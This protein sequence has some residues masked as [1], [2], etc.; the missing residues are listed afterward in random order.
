MSKIIYLDVPDVACAR[1]AVRIGRGVAINASSKHYVTASAG[2]YNLTC[3]LIADR[4]QQL[5]AENTALLRYGTACGT[6]KIVNYT[7]KKREMH[8]EFCI[9]CFE[10][11]IAQD[12]CV[13]VPCGHLFACKDCMRSVLATQDGCPICRKTIKRVGTHQ[14]VEKVFRS[15]VADV[16]NDDYCVAVRFSVGRGKR[17]K[18]YVDKIAWIENEKDLRKALVAAGCSTLSELAERAPSVFWSVF[19]F[20]REQNKDNECDME[21]EMQKMLTSNTIQH[22]EKGNEQEKNAKGKRKSKRKRTATVDE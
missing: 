5:K 18:Q 8:A 15:G 22:D 20:L 12:E 19:I 14:D 7:L 21:R 2:F 11:P 1:K 3:D 6:P 16:S 10:E 13:A 17:K 9:I 4:F